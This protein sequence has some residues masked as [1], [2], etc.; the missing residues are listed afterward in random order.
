[1]LKVG[2][3]VCGNDYESEPDFLAALFKGPIDVTQEA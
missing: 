2:I 3:N 1:M